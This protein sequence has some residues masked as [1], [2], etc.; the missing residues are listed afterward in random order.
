MGILHLILVFVL[1]QLSTS[2]RAIVER[3]RSA[4]QSAESEVSPRVIENAFSAARSVRDALTQKLES[5][6]DE[7]FQNVQ[8]L[9]GLLINREEVVLIKPNVD[10]FAKLAASRGDEADRTFFAALKTTYPESVWPSYVE[11]QTD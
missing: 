6:G 8:Q 10:Y 11:Q 5:L 2:D 7:E 4:I 3:Y 9:P 1:A